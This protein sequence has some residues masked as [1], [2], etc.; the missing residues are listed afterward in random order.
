MRASS[1]KSSLCLTLKMTTDS[2][3]LKAMTTTK[4]T[5]TRKRKMAVKT[6]ARKETIPPKVTMMKSRL[7]L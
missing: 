6:A 3:T 1:L 4:M 5:T 2:R 7:L